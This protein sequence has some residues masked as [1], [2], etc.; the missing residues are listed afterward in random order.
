MGFGREWQVWWQWL[1]Q[2]RTP[3]TELVSVSCR[4]PKLYWLAISLPQLRFLVCLSA[5]FLPS[6]FPLSVLYVYVYQNVLRC[7]CLS[8]VCKSAYAVKA[9]TGEIYL[10][11]HSETTH[12]VGHRV[13]WSTQ[14]R[15]KDAGKKEG[16]KRCICMAFFFYQK[17]GKE[18]E[19]IFSLPLHGSIRFI[20]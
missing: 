11:F 4:W 8:R 18:A 12:G 3:V 9:H 6:Y 16:L 15:W 19:V 2:D 7:T 5:G 10:C 1:W 14:R 20:P 13:F 17:G